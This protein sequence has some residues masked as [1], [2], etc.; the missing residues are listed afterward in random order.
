MKVNHNQ[1][2]LY[3]VLDYLYERRF[4]LKYAKMNQ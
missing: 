1:S 3:H 2:I 4:M